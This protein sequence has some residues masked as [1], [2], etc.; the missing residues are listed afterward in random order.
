MKNISVHYLIIA[1]FLF[2]VFG[3]SKD[4]PEASFSLS[5]VNENGTC[6]VGVDE[7][8][9]FTNLSTNADSYEWY[10]GD[11]EKSDLESPMHSYDEPG[12]YWV[13]LLASNKAGVTQ[14]FATVYVEDAPEG[15]VIRVCH[16][17][18]YQNEDYPWDDDAYLDSAEVYFFDNIDDYWYLNW[19]NK[20]HFGYTDEGGNVAFKNYEAGT[21]YYIVIFKEN[22]AQTGYY[23]N[24]NDTSLFAYVEAPEETK[25]V[26]MYLFPVKFV[27]YSTRLKLTVYE[28]GT[29]TPLDDCN[30]YLF[31]SQSYMQSE[32]TGY[33]IASGTTDSNGE[34]TFSDLDSRIYYYLIIKEETEGEYTNNLPGM[35]NSTGVLTE[36]ALNTETA[37]A[38]FI[39]YYTSLQFTVYE[40]GTSTPVDNCNIYLFTSLSDMQSENIPYAEYSGITNSSGQYTFD[41]IEAQ[42]YYYLLTK[43]SG[44]GTYSNNHSGMDNSTGALNEYQANTETGYV[45]YESSGTPFTSTFYNQVFTPIEITISGVTKICP[46]GGSCSFIWDDNPGSYSYHAET[47][48]ETSQGWQ[49]GELIE[50]DYT[51]NVGGLTSKTTN[52]I[53]GSLYFFMYMRNYGTATL[54]PIRVNV[55]IDL[56]T[57]Y[58]YIPNDNVKY[59]TGYFEAYTGTRV[60][61]DLMGTALY[62]YWIQGTHFSFP[63]TDNQSVELIN[64]NK[65]AQVKSSSVTIKNTGDID[66]S[67]RLLPA[68]EV[69]PFRYIDY[70]NADYGS[71]K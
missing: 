5:P 59:N 54:Y 65:K 63:W 6:I 18:Y 53:V 50:W 51:H 38:D 70:E 10:F 35:D 67:D 37:Y 64:S 60:E 52:L 1:S 46:V 36:Y 56:V 32:N 43:T 44:S 20:V 8:V 16:N 66:M 17:D 71:S 7:P 62:V 23:T 57:E 42:N 69:M 4:K 45:R 15:L 24:Y 11:G 47:S 22:D 55:G 41:D 14:A 27:P 33:A 48:G 12:T 19:E 25:Q 28:E 2:I 34:I 30:V 61:A 21:G 49:I 58:I 68:K 29:S 3:C 39:E 31:T 40:E 9:S 26:Q 13:T